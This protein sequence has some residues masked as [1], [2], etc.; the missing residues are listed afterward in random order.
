[1]L[2]GLGV[3][4]LTWAFIQISGEMIE[5]DTRSI[6]MLLLRAAQSLRADYPW[7]AEVMR[8]LSALGRL[9][10]GAAWALV[11]LLLARWLAPIHLAVPTH[12]NYRN[13]RPFM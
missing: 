12:Q 6:D 11:W 9:R 10:S 3:I 5:G 13:S 7:V 4:L 8:D 2:A 1:L